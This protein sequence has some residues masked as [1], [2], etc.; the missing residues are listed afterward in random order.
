MLWINIL[1]HGRN[2]W[3]NSWGKCKDLNEFI[4]RKSGEN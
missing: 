4:G 1:K 2:G 3:K